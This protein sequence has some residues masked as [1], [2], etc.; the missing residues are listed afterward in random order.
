[1]PT[2]MKARMAIW[3]NVNFKINST[4]QKAGGHS[5]IHMYQTIQA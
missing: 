5:V 3:E 4:K 1:M 2:K